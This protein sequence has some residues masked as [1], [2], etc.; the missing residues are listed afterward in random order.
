MGQST[1]ST[2]LSQ[3]K[4]A[5]LVEDRRTGKSNL[6]RL[7]A[8]TGRRR[9]LDELLARARTRN[10]RSRPRSGRHAPR[11]QETPGQDAQLLRQR[12]RP[13][14]QGLRSR[15]IVEERRRGTAPSDAAHDHRRS[16][17]RRRQLRAP[18][19]AARQKRHRRRLLRQDDRGRPR[20]GRSAIGVKNVEF[21]LG[22]MEELPI[23]DAAVDLVFFSQSL[24]H[25]LHPER[26]IAGG[27]ADSRAPAAA[28]SF[29]TSPSTASKRPANSTPTSGSASARRNWSRTL[30]QRGSRKCWPLLLIEK[31]SRRA[32]RRCWWLAPS[33]SPSLDLRRWGEPVPPHNLAD[34]CEVRRASR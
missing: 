6:Y 27:R 26:A 9:V 21:R 23:D 8:S 2:H 24:H 11:R 32:F 7:T 12:C 33:R 34:G 5:G 15:Q 14:R 29:S 19:R 17:R 28:S 20:A 30:L 10:P 13:P 3:L 16:G 22:D 31:T 18:P 25:A 4:Q 1:I